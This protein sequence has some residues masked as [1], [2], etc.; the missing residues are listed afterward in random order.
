MRHQ[1]HFIAFWDQVHVIGFRDQGNILEG[2]E[3]GALPNVLGIGELQSA[4]GSGAL[5]KGRGEQRQIIV[6]E[7]PR[8]RDGH[9]SEEEKVIRCFVENSY[10]PPTPPLPRLSWP[11]D[12]Y[13]VDMCKRDL[14]KGQSLPPP[15]H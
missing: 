1:G 7:G 5:Y 6:G 10:G 4:E 12:H 9:F 2:K 8:V 13:S 3:P 11:L 15:P 14:T